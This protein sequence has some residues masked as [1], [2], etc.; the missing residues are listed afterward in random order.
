MDD[1]VHEIF[2]LLNN[3]DIVAAHNYD[4]SRYEIP[5]VPSAF[6][7]YNTGVIAYWMSERFEDFLSEWEM[8]YKELSSTEIPQNQPAFRKALYNSNLRIATL[9]PEYNLMVR[10]PGHAIGTVKLFHGRLL[11]I[12][13]PGAEMHYDIPAAAEK[14]NSTT[15]HRVFTQLGGLTIHSNKEDHPIHY[16]RMVLERNGIFGT[17]SKVC[18]RT[19]NKILK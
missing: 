4:R 8:W 5:D 2:D 14:I 1:P 19:H 10:Y 7:E 15:E 9:P 6:P 13:S 3:F 12:D 18:E 17:V 11:D 16:A